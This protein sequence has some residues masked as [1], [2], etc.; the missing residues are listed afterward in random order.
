MAGIRT[1]GY[2]FKPVFRVL[3]RR[4]YAMDSLEAFDFTRRRAPGQ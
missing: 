1:G 4:G 3:R 2:D